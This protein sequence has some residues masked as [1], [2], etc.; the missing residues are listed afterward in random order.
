MKKVFINVVCFFIA[1]TALSQK[2]TTTDLQ[3]LLTLFEGEFDNFQQVYKEKEDKVKEPHEHIHSI[4]KKIDLPALGQNIFY[5]IQ[6]MDG[7]TTKIYRQRLYSFNNDKKQKAIR[8]DIYTFKVDS[9][10]YYSNIYPKKLMGL[11]VQDINGVEGCSVFWKKIG[12]NFVGYMPPN[13]CHFVSKR[14]GK[15]FM[16]PIVYC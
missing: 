13:K 9:L 5:V 2:N 15:Q 3:Q 11:T 6:Y 16:Q 4:F 14:S 10:F 7:D 12:E 8:L 1:L